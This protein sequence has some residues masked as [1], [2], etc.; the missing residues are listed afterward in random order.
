M[1]A[2]LKPGSGRIWCTA[3]ESWPNRSGREKVVFAGFWMDV[4][5]K[6]EGRFSYWGLLCRYD[7]VWRKSLG[8][9]SKEA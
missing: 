3:F 6:K 4:C 5:V 7:E 2:F 1:L 9:A 8:M